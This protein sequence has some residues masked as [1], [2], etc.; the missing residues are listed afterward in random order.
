MKNKKINANQNIWS[1]KSKYQK[2]NI[3][4][5]CVSQIKSKWYLIKDYIKILRDRYWCRYLISKN[6]L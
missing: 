3:I 1:C 4:I 5:L 6:K 2:K